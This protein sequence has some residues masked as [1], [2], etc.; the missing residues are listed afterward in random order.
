M[1]K[2]LIC[3]LLIFAVTVVSAGA[4]EYS[5]DKHSFSMDLCEGMS[6]NDVVLL[7]EILIRYGFYDGEADGIYGPAMTEAVKGLEQYLQVMCGYEQ[8]RCEEALMPK[9]VSVAPAPAEESGDGEEMAA[10][11]ETTDAEETADTEETPEPQTTPV[12]AAYLPGEYAVY[13]VDGVADVKLLNLLGNDAIDFYV[14]EVE[15]MVKNEDARRAQTRLIQLNYLDG[16]A[17]GVFGENSMAAMRQFQ[18]DNGLEVTGLPNGESRLVLFDSSAARAER[19]I[20]NLLV[21]SRIESDQ[22]ME[23]QKRLNTYGFTL[24]VPDGLYGSKTEEMLT[25]FKEYLFETGRM[26]AYNE[27]GGEIIY[28]EDGTPLPRVPTVN[29]SHE[30]QAHLLDGDFDVYHVTLQEGSQYTS[31]VLRLQRRLFQL[32]F[33]IVESRVDGEYGGKTVEGLTNFQLRNGLPATGVA[34]ETTQRLLFSEDAK[35]VLKPYLIRVSLEEQRA[36]IYTYDANEEYTVLERTI[37]ISSGAEESPTPT[38]T[39]EFTGKGERWHYFEAFNSWAQ[40]A[41]HIDGDIMFHSVIYDRKDDESSLQ[42][43]TRT[44]LGYPASHGCIR[45][46]VEDAQWI[47]ENCPTRTTVIIEGPETEPE[48]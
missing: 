29:A 35:K 44:Y 2:W 25:D 20:Y 7:Q 40:Y 19:P 39:F 8:A 16:T 28:A 37:V 31:D 15:P 30:L 32:G 6:G 5:A 47:W 4:S 21:E 11:E 24:E 36:Y 33:L 38:G 26:N 22:V 10:G 41:F 12:P 18:R 45:M 23:L 13:E 46:E 48:E 3:A 1:R 27:L 34:D 17:D 43:S 9:A 14:G 42:V